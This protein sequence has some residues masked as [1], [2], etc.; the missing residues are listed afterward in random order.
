MRSDQDPALLRA[1]AA[2]LK[3]RRL[4]LGLSQDKFALM[5]EIHRTF[6]AKVERAVAMPSLSSVYRIAEGL[7]AE[8]AELITAVSKRYMKE[9]RSAVS[10]A[11]TSTA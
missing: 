3:A 5:A 8:P 11:P 4:A 9:L 10:V 1:F 7:G 6:V 2:E